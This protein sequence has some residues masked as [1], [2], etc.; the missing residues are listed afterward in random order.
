MKKV[1]AGLGL[2]VIITFGVILFSNYKYN[3]NLFSN[4]PSEKWSKE[5]VVGQSKAKNNPIIIK[6]QNKLLIAYD[7]EKTLNVTERRLTGEEINSFQYKA[8][9]E[10]MKNVVFLE[11]KEGY[12]LSYNSTKE[13]KPYS[14]EI[15]LDKNLNEINRKIT[16]GVEFIFQSDSNTFIRKINNTIEVIDTI[17]DSKYSVNVNEN[18]VKE[19]TACNIEGGVLV[20]YLENETFK[21][22]K[23]INGVGTNPMDIRKV[24]QSEKFHYTGI[25]CS[26]DD[27]DGYLIL[28]ESVGNEFVGARMIQFK[29]DGSASEIKQL[30]V[31]EDRYLSGNVGVY[32]KNE[33]RFYA[34]SD[35]VLG[36]KYPQRDI[37]SYTIKDGETSKKEL[38]TRVK[39]PCM[40][41]YIEEDL[42]TFISF[43]STNLYDINIQSTSEEFKA[44]NNTI[45]SDE[46]KTA[47]IYTFQG[48]FNSL[49]YIFIIGLQWIIIPLTVAAIASFFDYKLSHK[50]KSLIFIGLGI[51]AALYKTYQIINIC[52]GNNLY[53]LPSSI[54]SIGMG[55]LICLLLSMLSY[56]FGYAMYKRDMDNV[57]IMSFSTSIIID[58]ILTLMV[59][60]PYII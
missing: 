34:I 36:K 12:I 5:V 32:S 56:S 27:K 15:Y 25:A 31:E 40:Y 9:E 1:F 24:E 48:F 59:Y 8:E 38:V 51:I 47:T 11:T 54:A 58:S 22:F 17:K 14:E 57:M 21:F 44:A 50:K 35:V 2:T 39:G 37:V 4:P 10:L 49:G 41:P 55:I 28:E 46:R 26:A 23:V 3:I 53:L 60:V 29:L 16:E 30:Y 7:G 6:L 52:Y 18:Q 45:R 33:A 13:Q 19:L 42:V 43:K 20:A